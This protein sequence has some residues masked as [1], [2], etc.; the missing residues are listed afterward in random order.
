M[1]KFAW[2]TIIALAIAAGAYSAYAL[3][4]SDMSSSSSSKVLAQVLSVSGDNVTLYY[5]GASEGKVFCADENVP[6][7]S[8]NVLKGNVSLVGEVRISKL[9]SP[10]Y[11]EGSLVAGGA[12]I[13]NIASKPSAMCLKG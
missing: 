10:R 12:D 13:G 3:T 5:G 4:G 8:Q 2:L 11:V 9:I 6:I 1:K 7:F